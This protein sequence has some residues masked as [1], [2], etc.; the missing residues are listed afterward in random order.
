MKTSSLDGFAGVLHQIF[1]KEKNV[2]HIYFFRKKEEK[3]PNW[4]YEGSITITSKAD[5]NPATQE[6][7]IRRIMFTSQPRQIVHK[8]LS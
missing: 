1:M 3:L 5:K 8:T 6:A 4:F 7:E 2:I